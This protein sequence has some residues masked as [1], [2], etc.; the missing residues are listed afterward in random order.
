MGA[1]L[2]ETPYGRN[3]FE[4]QLPKLIMAIEKLA[5]RVEP[6]KADEPKLHRSKFTREDEQKLNAIISCPKKSEQFAEL[7]RKEMSTDE[8]TLEK[9]GRYAAQAIL[10]GSFND[11]LLAICG[12]TASGLLEKMQPTDCED[13]K[14]CD[15]GGNKND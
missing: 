13:C 3:F 7:I 6:V 1:Q 15:N 11:L 4:C 12:W 8:E 10:N 2:H 14:D 5:D 9:V